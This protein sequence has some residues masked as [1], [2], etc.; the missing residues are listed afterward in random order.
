MSIKDRQG[1]RKSFSLR[2]NDL[3][4]KQQEYAYITWLNH[5][6]KNDPKIE[7]LKEHV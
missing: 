6:N 3:F 2:Q 1:I 5:V 7:N 4:K